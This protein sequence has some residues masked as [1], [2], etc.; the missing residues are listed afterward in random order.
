MRR[1]P[2]PT[3]RSAEGQKP[4]GVIGSLMR[5]CVELEMQT[6]VEPADL[7]AL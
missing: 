1:G 5:L 7:G 4:A 6:L 2:P 3:A